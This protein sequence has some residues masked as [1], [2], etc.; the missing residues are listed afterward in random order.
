MEYAEFR[1][2]SRLREVWLRLKT[3]KAALFGLVIFILLLLMAAFA[4]QIVPYE[5]AIEQNSAERF[6]PPFT[7]HWFGTD[8]F[9]RDLFAR[10]VHGATTSITLGIIAV[11]I[12][13]IIGTI[14]GTIAGY[15][16]GIID[17]VIMRLVDIQMAIPALLMAIA[18]VSALGASTQNLIIAMS[19][20]FIPNHVRMIRASTMSLRGMDYI[21]AARA[22]GGSTSHIIRRH[23]LI[24]VVATIIV[25]ASMGVADAI[26]LISTLSYLGLGAQAPTPEWGGLLS[27]GRDYIIRAPHLILI[28]GFF[29]LLITLAL[30]LLG[31]GLRD[32]FDPKLK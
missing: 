3:N 28:P 4:E 7:E 26:M 6:L 5:V 16:G 32:A 2:R 29:L 15:F 1:E 24:N 10:V 17:T 20:A 27:T 13:T 11:A 18:I 8:E 31:D 14:I 25:Q 23:V 21:E 30:N 19:I 9:G 12:S 22:L